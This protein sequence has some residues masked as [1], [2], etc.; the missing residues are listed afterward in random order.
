MIPVSGVVFQTAVSVVEIRSNSLS[1]RCLFGSHCR[2][3]NFLLLIN[4]IYNKLC[5]LNIVKPLGP[6][7]L[8]PRVL[9]KLLPWDVIASIF[10]LT[11]GRSLQCGKVPAD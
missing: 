9:H 6:D 3:D 11:Y 4:S 2:P 10:F 7:T 5:N 8:H 1:L